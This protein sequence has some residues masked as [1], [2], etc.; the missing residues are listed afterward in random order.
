MQW[1]KLLLLWIC[2]LHQSIG[3]AFDA[4]YILLQEETWS[5]FKPLQNSSLISKQLECHQDH[6]NAIPNLQLTMG[7]TFFNSL[8][9]T[10][11]SPAAGWMQ[12]MSSFQE[13]WVKIKQD[14]KN[15]KIINSREDLKAYSDQFKGIGKFPGTYCIYPRED[16]IPIVHISRKCPIVIRPLIDKKL[17]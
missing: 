14:M 16:A 3:P 13:A 1:Q 4:R 11:P 2:L 17:E 6:E 10:E 7:P 12:I 9:L 8:L 5:T 15:L